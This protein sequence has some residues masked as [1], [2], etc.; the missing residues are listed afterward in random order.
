M[1]PSL[2]SPDSAVGIAPPLEVKPPP[3]PQNFT[4]LPE[5]GKP[6]ITEP[7]KYSEPT[8]TDPKIDQLMANIMSQAGATNPKDAAKA[9]EQSLPAEIKKKPGLIVQII[10]WLFNLLTLGIFKKK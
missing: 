1:S 8:T 10:Q 4:P 3:E 6:T 2:S 9:V 5:F 7:P